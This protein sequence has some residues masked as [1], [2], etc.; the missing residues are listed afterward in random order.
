MPNDNYNSTLGLLGQTMPPQNSLAQLGGLLGQNP[1]HPPEW[2]NRGVRN[3]AGGLLGGLADLATF[4]GRYA[5]GQTGYTPGQM[6]SEQPQATN[7]AAEM[8][9]NAVGMGTPFAQAGAL[10]S[11]GG[12]GIKAY[13]GSPHDFDRFDLSKIGTGEG[14]QAYGHGLYF[15][16]NVD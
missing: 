6:A 12:K 8:A 5:S 14:A 11:A 10:G 3:V 9:T 2:W 13:H 15:A 7:W 4:P 16:E 1:A